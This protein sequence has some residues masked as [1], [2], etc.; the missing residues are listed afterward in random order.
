MQDFDNS[1]IAQLLDYL[2]RLLTENQQFRHSHVFGMLTD[3]F[4]IQLFRVT[5]LHRSSELSVVSNQDVK[6]HG[7]K[8]QFLSKPEGR[9]LL[10]TFMNLSDEE[11]GFTLPPLVV[12][13]TEPGFASLKGIQMQMIRFMGSG[14]HATVYAVQS[15]V[16][17]FNRYICLCT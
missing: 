9:N 13:Q 6:Y 17:N 7:G 12:T 10:Y 14:A 5:R 3:G 11:L 8:P 2:G 16:C 4:V 15:E 1:E